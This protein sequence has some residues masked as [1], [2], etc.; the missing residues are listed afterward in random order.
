MFGR[1][2]RTGLGSL[3][4]S[5]QGAFAA[6]VFRVVKEYLA[7]E[8]NL[9]ISRDENTTVIDRWIGTRLEAISQLQNFGAV[10]LE[11][12]TD[13]NKHP[14][15]LESLVHEAGNSMSVAFFSPRKATGDAIK[16]AISAI[17]NVYDYLNGLEV[18][19]AI[20]FRFQL[21][22]SVSNGS[23]LRYSGLVLE[24]QRLLLKW[25]AFQIA[26]EW[27]N[28]PAGVVRPEQPET[29]FMRLWR[30]VTFRTKMIAIC[31]RW[32][33]NYLASFAAACK[34]AADRDRLEGRYDELAAVEAHD[35]FVK[36]LSADDPDGLQR[37]SFYPIA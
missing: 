14:L 33:P 36:I 15:L 5:D 19:L 13:P 1:F 4:R 30:D 34:L 37:T 17:L 32:G 11:L 8:K 18:E 20:P 22:E 24:M 31:S 26:T 6:A 3:L 2:A 16:D 10:K 27:K 35:R 7:N 23:V 28:A 12:I 29:I 9:P 25:Q 21:R